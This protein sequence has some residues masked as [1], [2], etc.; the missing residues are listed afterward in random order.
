M[1]TETDVL[2]FFRGELS[3]PVS[4]KTGRVPLE[5]DTVLQDYAELDE[6]PYAIDDYSE[7][8]SV[9]ISAMNIQAYYPS[10]EAS[11]FSRLFKSRQINDDMKRIRKPLTVRMFT[12]SAKA[13]K[14][15]YD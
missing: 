5:M 15:L 14:W 11:L 12:E 9:D 8:F 2:E 1:V 13:G 10:V 3:V 7:K 4:F 6:L